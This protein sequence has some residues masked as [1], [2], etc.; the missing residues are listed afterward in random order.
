MVYA[1]LL[2]NYFQNNHLTFEGNVNEYIELFNKQS[3]SPYLYYV[4]GNSFFS[5]YLASVKV[6]ERFFNIEK[7]LNT[8]FDD[9]NIPHFYIK[10][11]VLSKIYPDT[12]LRTRGDIDVV[13]KEEDEEK[14]TKLLLDNGFEYESKCYH[15]IGFK[16]N[17]LEIEVHTKMLSSDFKIRDLFED[18]FEHAEL[19]DKSL[20]KLNDTYHYLFCLF[21]FN[22]HLKTAEG[23]RYLL[24]FYYMQQKFALNYDLLD[25]LIKKYN[26]ETL[27]KNIINSIFII[28]NEKLHG[29]TNEDSKFFIEY[30]E[31]NGIHGKNTDLLARDI[32]KSKSKTYY[33][34]NKIFLFDKDSRKELYPK[35]SKHKIYYPIL[36]IHRIF[37]LLFTKLRLGIRALKVK[38]V[39]KDEYNEFLNKIGVVEL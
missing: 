31:S 26:L 4:Y 22:K 13:I 9:N 5:V 32:Y 1:N 35:L 21:H 30:L 3:L 36:V 15:H 23:L 29:F 27:H 34:L 2:I 25:G 18:T 16:K 20:Y 17:K 38:N 39:N 8:L 6:Q 24:D 11:T 33:L 7:Q 12:A 37:K 10:G 14:V 19:V 28:T